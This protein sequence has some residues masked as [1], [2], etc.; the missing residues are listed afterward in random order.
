MNYRIKG[1]CLCVKCVS[2]LIGGGFI[3]LIFIKYFIVCFCFV[4]NS[5]C[6]VNCF[7]GVYSFDKVKRKKFINI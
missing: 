5:I 2:Y 7:I 6:F 3:F 1:L 4:Y